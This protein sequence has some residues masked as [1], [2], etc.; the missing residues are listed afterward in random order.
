MLIAILTLLLLNG[1]V[2]TDRNVDGPNIVYILADDLGW[3]EVGCYGQEKIRTPVMDKLSR[4]GMRFTQHYSGS[5]VCAPSRCVLLT[6]KHTGHAIVRNNWEN[7]G[8]GADEPEGQY[9]LPESEE[10]IAE[11]LK[12]RGYVTACIGKWGLGGPDTIGHPNKQGSTISYGYLCQPQRTTTIPPIC[13]ETTRSTSSMTVSSTAHQRIESPLDSEQAYR[14][15]YDRKDYTPDLMRD[16]A[17]EFIRSNADKPFFPLLPEP[18]S[19]CG[20]PG[21]AGGDRGVPP[22]MG[23]G[24]LSR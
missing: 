11:M 19:P 22:R 9:P 6:G 16:E 8:W 20:H 23:S 5:A 12:E 17:I 24:T 18:D 3:G 14:D 7:G 15:A 1:P 4:E 13:G 2:E 10:T 21:S